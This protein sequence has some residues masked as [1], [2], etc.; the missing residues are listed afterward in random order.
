MTWLTHQRVGKAD[1]YSLTDGLF[2]LDG[3]SMFGSVPKVLWNQVAPADADNRIQLRIN[4]LLIRL[5]GQNIL[6]ETGMWDRGG[7]K[8]DEMYAIERDETTFRGLGE[9]GLE[10]DDIHY[11][12]NTHLHFDHSGRNTNL[13]GEPT[14]PNAR[15]IVQRQELHDATHTH[16]R[17]RASYVPETFVPIMEADLFDVVEGET[18]IVPG[19]TVL[20]LPGH[21]LGQQGA[22]L[23]SEGQTLVY[24]ADLIA[25][26]AHAP[27]P[28]VMGFDLYPVTCLETR[29]KYL[30]QW[31]EQGATICT[32][33]DPKVPF[34][35]LVEGKRGYR[36]EAVGEDSAV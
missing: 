8:F 18:E 26:T 9:L 10:P 17:S 21:N 7:E 23:H 36:L 14:F 20:P 27:Y 35:R 33:H 19:V 16:E 25:T 32:P 5:N 1:V 24:T 4:P 2:R 6:I 34:A 11:V 12:I 29:K 15:Y 22:V 13:I 28:Y 30:P 3:G 31:H